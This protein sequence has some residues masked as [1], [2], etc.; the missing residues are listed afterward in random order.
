[1]REGEERAMRHRSVAA[2]L[3]SPSRYE[4]ILVSSSPRCRLRGRHRTP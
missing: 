2:V 4:V 1:M 3:P